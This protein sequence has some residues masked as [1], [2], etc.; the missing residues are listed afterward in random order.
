MSGEDPQPSAEE[1]EAIQRD[2]LHHEAE[3]ADDA[4]DDGEERTHGRRAD[5]AA[6]LVEKL[7]EQQEADER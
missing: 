7:Q 4:L 6:Y 3:A 2:R 5:K 1:L